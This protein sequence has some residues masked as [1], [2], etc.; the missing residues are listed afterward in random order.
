MESLFA[1][2][3][4]LVTGASS[5]LGAQF[6]KQVAAAR[7]NVI[8]TSRSRDKLE[9]L[10]STLAA[11]Y[12]VEARAIATDLGQPGGAGIL[13]REVEALGVPVDHLIANAGFGVAGPVS[14]ADP[15]RLG[16]MVRVNCEVVTVLSRLALG[17]MLERGRGGI[18]HVASTASFQP[19]PFMAVY[20]AT[21]AFVLS[22]SAA[23]AEEVRGRGLR[24]MALCPGPVPTGFQD[25]A[26]FEIAP[27][28]RLATLSAEDTVTRALEAYREER[29]VFIPGAVN[30][31]SSIGSKLMPRR[32][33]LKT[34]AKMMRSR[35]E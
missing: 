23:L 15:E 25:T 27:S 20:A 24:V 31:L 8:V 29:D 32:L 4:V 14:A 9:A 30:Y 2:S 12:G 28:Q 5:G 3:W 17:P 10:A 16:E 21:K 6:A 13:W 26:G 22:F 18:L 33:L 19:V 11:E 1:G 35:G 34:V 7:G